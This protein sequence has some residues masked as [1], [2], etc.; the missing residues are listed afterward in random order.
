MEETGVKAKFISILGFRELLSY[1]FGHPDIY[2]VCLMEAE[3]E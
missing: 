2:F 3:S 1:K